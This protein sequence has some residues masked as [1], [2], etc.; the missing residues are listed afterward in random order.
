MYHSCPPTLQPSRPGPVP[1]Q[2]HARTRSSLISVGVS[3]RQLFRGCTGCVCH[4]QSIVKEIKTTYNIKN[5]IWKGKRPLSTVGLFPTY[6]QTWLRAADTTNACICYQLIAVVNKYKLVTPTC[7]GYWDL[8]SSG[9][10]VSQEKLKVLQ[11][12]VIFVDWNVVYIKQHNCHINRG[13]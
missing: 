2:L 13:Y 1:V 9:N 12:V 3:A 4:K 5:I 11:H 8:S 7:F 10:I 6:A